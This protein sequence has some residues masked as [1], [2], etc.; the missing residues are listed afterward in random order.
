MYCNL[1]EETL[2]QKLKT[3][4]HVK[5]LFSNLDFFQICPVSTEEELKSLV[6][7]PNERTK[8]LRIIRNFCKR[9]FG[10]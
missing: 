1:T 10:E 6:N 3:D 2:L 5:A 7:K 9:E 8:L 4:H